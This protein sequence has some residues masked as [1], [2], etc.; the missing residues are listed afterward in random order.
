[1]PLIHALLSGC[2]MLELIC[3]PEDDKPAPKPVLERRARYIKDIVLS[4]NFRL[5]ATADAEGALWLWD[6]KSF[7]KSRLLR[8]PNR[9]NGIA[10]SP[11]GKTVAALTHFTD[12]VGFSTGDIVQL[13]NVS[14][15]KLIHT[16]K[17][18][19]D[20]DPVSSLH[21]SVAFSPDGKVL[22]TLSNNHT[23][24]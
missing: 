22:T 24:T 17:I 23:G 16:F 12:K 18:K 8:T 13:W 15:G 11:D 2:F 20:G 6:Y 10:F 1:V 3:V 21:S 19:D 5:V 14:E 4:P 9:I 7:K